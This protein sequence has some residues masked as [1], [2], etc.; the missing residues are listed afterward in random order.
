MGMWWIDK[1]CL[2]NDDNN[3]INDENV[4][5]NKLI[6]SIRSS[7]LRLKG[8]SMS[9]DGTKV[10]YTGIKDSK[11]FHT[12]LD[13]VSK[14]KNIKLEEIEQHQKK[15]FWINIYNSLII[16][17]QVIGL[18]N[19]KGGIRDRLKLYASASYNIGGYLFSLNDIENGILRGNRK[20]P[21]PFSST[22]F[23]NDNPIL[24]FILINDPRIHFALNCGAKSCPPIAIYSLE[25]DVIERNLKLATE[26]FLENN[27]E[28][29][30]NNKTIT[31]TKIFKWYLIDFGNSHE[32]LLKYMA[33]NSAIELGKKIN[34]CINNKY[35][36]KFKEYDWSLNSD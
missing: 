28:I 29:N 31:T 2:N 9:E 32:E 25:E 3:N 12:Y 1:V 17:A 18:T 10:K 34:E 26:L 14:L 11:T 8:E 21:T 15:G 23:S 19:N 33:I 36:I 27:I 24:P 6:T 35:K 4:A 30:D 5:I 16:H 22:P 13:H 7:M 20:S